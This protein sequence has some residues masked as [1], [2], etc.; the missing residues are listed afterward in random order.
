M[1]PTDKAVTASSDSCPRSQRW[2][3]NKSHTAVGLILYDRPHK[4]QKGGVL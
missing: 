1:K 2:E 3:A 4:R